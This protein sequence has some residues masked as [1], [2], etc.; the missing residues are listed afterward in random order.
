MEFPII[1]LL[2]DCRGGGNYVRG[3]SITGPEA[4]TAEKPMEPQKMEGIRV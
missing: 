3:A 1:A 4:A 2:Y